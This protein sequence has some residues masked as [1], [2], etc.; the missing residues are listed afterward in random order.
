MSGKPSGR[1]APTRPAPRSRPLLAAAALLLAAGCLPQARFSLSGSITAPPHIQKKA[2]LPN[3]VLFI[4]ATN[5]AGVPVAVKRIINPT[6]PLRYQFHADDLVLPGKV[7]QG[8]LTVKVFVNSHG[9]LGEVQKGDL[10]GAYH[11]SAYA[12]D[13]DVDIVID[14]QV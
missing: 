9:R 10:T 3:T 6:F 2:E 11:G 14:R 5:A 1:T 13:R 7:W 4:V 12:G 8:P